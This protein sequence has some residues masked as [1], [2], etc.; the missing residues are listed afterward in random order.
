MHD[1]DNYRAAFLKPAGGG[2]LSLMNSN[3]TDEGERE[4]INQIES[5]AMMGGASPSFLR[6]EPADPGSSLVAVGPEQLQHSSSVDVVAS[7]GEH[8]LRFN[9][10]NSGFGEQGFFFVT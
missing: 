1:L 4:G 3:K 8:V 7:G 10:D 2:F 6:T 5:G 9:D